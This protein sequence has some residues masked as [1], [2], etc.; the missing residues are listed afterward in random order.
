MVHIILG[1]QSPRR[2]EILSSFSL[3]FTQVTSNFDEDSIP[4]S[5]NPASFACRLS[6]GKA[7]ALQPLYP[8]AVILTADTIVYREGKIYGKPENVDTAFRTLSELEG[9]WHSVF[10]GLTLLFEKHEYHQAEETKVLF[11]PLTSNQIKA[12]N[13]TSYW[14]DKAGGYG[15]QMGGGIVIKKIEGCFYNVLGLPI[16]AVR[17]LLQ[18]IGIDL[19]EYLK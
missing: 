10:T 19:W 5:G 2:K 4:F 7:Y 1:S 12:Y 11:N 3:A 16:N 17:E 13:Q 9:K 18:K 6:K 14:S 8:N 15:I